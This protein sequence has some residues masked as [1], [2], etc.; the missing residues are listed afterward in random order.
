MAGNRNR[1]DLPIMPARSIADQ[2]YERT[3]EQI[4]KGILAPGQRLHELDVAKASQTSRT[5]VREAFRRL[6]QDGLVERV[7]RGGVRVVSLDWETIKDLY[8]LRTVLE[9]HVIELACQRI[10]SE[11]IIALK[12]TK[13]QAMELLNSTDMDKETLL[14]HLLE[15]NTEFHDTIYQSTGSRFLINTV[16]QLRGIVMAMR[17]VSLQAERGPALTWEEHS[18]LIQHFEKRDVEAARKLIRRHIQ[19][20]AREVLSVMKQ[21]DHANVVEI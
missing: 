19:N 18:Q 17:S 12:R 4:L 8:Q 21:L 6:E 13:A 14:S 16:N 9:I 2:L 11:E 10:S 7:P 3:K 1:N 5:P 20:A 15:L